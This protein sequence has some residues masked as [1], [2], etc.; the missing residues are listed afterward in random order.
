MAILAGG[1]NR[2]FNGRIKALLPWKG[3]TLI[4]HQ[5]DIFSDLTGDLMVITH[6]PELL[7]LP[8]TPMYKDILPGGGPLSGI[9]AALHNATCSHTLVVAC[10]MPFVSPQ[11]ITELITASAQHPHLVIAPTHAKGV[12]TLFSLWPATILSTLDK[13]LKEDQSKRILDFLEHHLCLF[14]M[15][16]ETNPNS[17]TNINTAKDLELASAISQN[18]QHNQHNNDVVKD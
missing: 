16:T 2:R 6:H 12:E 10:D 4:R 7:N 17:F 9:H 3:K 11:V 8:G 14:K 13:W 15:K 18:V 5:I 1:R